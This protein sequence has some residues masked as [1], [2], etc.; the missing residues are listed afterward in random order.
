VPLLAGHTFV[1]VA[2]GRKARG[3][4]AVGKEVDEPGSETQLTRL[5]RR[6][7]AGAGIV[8][9]PPECAIQLRRV[10]HRFVDREPEMGRVQHKV[11]FTRT[12]GLRPQLLNRI[13]ARLFGL[14]EPIPRVHV[15]VAHL[16]RAAE[17]IAALKIARLAIDGSHAKGRVRADYI[18]LDSRAVGRREILLFIDEG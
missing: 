8:R 11:I 5:V 6:E 10:A 1:V 14:L 9:F 17:R 18:L 12:H 15:L 16:L 4:Y 7:K 13:L 2:D 3:L